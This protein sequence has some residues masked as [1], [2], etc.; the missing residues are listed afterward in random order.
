MRLSDFPQ[1]FRGPAIEGIPA[2]YCAM[3]GD[4][5][6]SEP[7]SYDAAEQERARLR[8]DRVEQVR[9]CPGGCGAT[10]P[11]SCRCSCLDY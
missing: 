10:V 7:S 9:E 11:V 2:V 5:I 8:A 1:H 4:Q 3:R 6:V